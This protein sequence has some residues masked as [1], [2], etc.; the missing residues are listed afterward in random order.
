MLQVRKRISVAGFDAEEIAEGLQYF[1]DEFKHRTW[2]IN[3]EPSGLT[4]A[5][6]F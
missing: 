1:V 2:L 4:G 3:R 6:V 5:V